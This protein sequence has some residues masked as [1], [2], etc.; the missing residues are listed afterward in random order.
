V[1]CSDGQRGV[2]YNLWCSRYR[3]DGTCPGVHRTRAAV[4]AAFALWLTKYAVDLERATREAIRVQPLQPR[5]DHRDAARQRATKAIDNADATSSRLLDA[6]ADG[7]ITL[8]EYKSRCDGI[9]AEV[10]IARSQLAEL[11]VAAEE[12]PS[13]PTV[14]SFVELWPTLTARAR[15]DVA[16]ALVREVRVQC[17]KSVVIVPRWGEPV[18]VTFTRRNTVPVLAQAG[19]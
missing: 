12:P 16:E 19:Q 6:Y 11:N 15:H 8:G 17:D 3:Q 1:Y 18:T 5:T 7:A 13:A 14:D 2:Q 4:E 10:G 9:E